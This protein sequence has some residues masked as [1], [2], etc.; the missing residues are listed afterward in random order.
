MHVLGARRMND[1][2]ARERAFHNEAIGDQRRR[3]LHRFYNLCRDARDEFERSVFHG[4]RG[5]RVLEFGCGPGALALELAECGAQVT[6]IDIS[7]LAIERARDAARRRGL[8]ERSEFRVMDAESLEF[9]PGTFD[10]VCGSGIIHHLD[11]EQ[12]YVEIASVLK[13][14]GR[15]VFLEPLG[16]NPL[17]NLVRLLTPHFRSND[18]R[19]LRLRDMEEARACF[20]LVNASYHYLIAP[21]F[22]LLPGPAGEPAVEL[23]NR[24]DSILLRIPGLQALA[25]QCVIY[26]RG[27]FS[28]PER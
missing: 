11:V 21:A 2:I 20:S 4:I 18:E 5:R 14:N 26:M 9:D 6:G 24:L 17:V 22:A 25:W 1:R 27:P 10:L 8:A 7:E 13:P 16:L 23:V 3:P 15:A 28:R 12:A 19:P